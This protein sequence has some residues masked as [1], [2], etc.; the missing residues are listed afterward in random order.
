M[1][2]ASLKDAAN[3]AA[4]KL[5]YAR[6]VKEEQLEVVV[7]F[8]SGSY[9]FAVLPT[10]LGKSLCYACLPFAF[11]LLGETEEKPIVVVVTPLTA[12]MVTYLFCIKLYERHPYTSDLHKYKYCVM[13]DPFPAERFGNGSGYARLSL[14][15]VATCI[16]TH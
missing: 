2:N 5:R 15:R 6:G 11:E 16:S 1:K 14:Y 8:L 4:M 7:A 13:Q 12:I 3:W 9:V 10:G